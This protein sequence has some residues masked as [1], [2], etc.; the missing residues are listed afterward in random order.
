MKKTETTNVFTN[1][2]M[3]DINPLV[4]PNNV[5]SNALNATLITRNGNE[6]AL[7][8]DMGNCRVETA[9]LPEGY[10][11]LGTAQLGGIIYIVSYNPLIN[12]CQIGSFPSPERN[13][14]SDEYSDLNQRLSSD[15]FLTDVRYEISTEGQYIRDAKIQ[16][17]LSKKQI[18][19]STL[20]SGDKY[21][22]GATGL[23]NTDETFNNIVELNELNKYVKLSLATIDSNGRLV[24]LNTQN[25]Y[26]LTDDKKF[27]IYNGAI[28]SNTST[29]LDDYRSVINSPFQI[30]SSKIA[31]NLW[32]IAELRVIDTFNVTY[33]WTGYKEYELQSELQSEY[34]FK[35]QVTTTPEDIGIKYVQLHEFT[36]SNGNENN[37]FIDG[38][39]I[40][41]LKLFQERSEEDSIDN[42]SFELAISGNKDNIGGNTQ[43]IVTPCMPF[44]RYPQLDSTITINFDLIGSG[45]IQNTTWRY[46]KQD[47]SMY[48]LWDI[49]VYPRDN[50][51]VNS[52]ALM[53]YEFTS[54]ES[55]P[56]IEG[57]RGTSYDFQSDP[58]T[59][60]YK[61]N[62][63]SY[64]G[65]YSDYVQFSNNF[66][67]DTLYFVNIVIE[68]YNSDANKYEYRLY[69]KV[70][71]TNGVYNQ[72]YL[73]SNELDFDNVP[74]DLTCQ[75][76]FK[77]IQSAKLQYSSHTPD[78]ISENAIDEPL[79]G[80]DEYKCENAQEV[81]KGD[82]SF[83]DSYNTFS[84]DN[85]G[86][87]LLVNRGTASFNGTKQ[88]EVQSTNEQFNDEWVSDTSVPSKGD[89][90]YDYFNI[91]LS[92]DQEFS[93]NNREITFSL[94]GAI[95]NKVSANSKLSQATVNNYIAP[96]V[97][98]EQTL[99]KYNMSCRQEDGKVNCYWNTRYY[100]LGISAG[101]GDNNGTNSNYY[102][103]GQRTLTQ[104]DTEDKVTERLM[105]RCNAAEVLIGD[106]HVDNDNILSVIPDITNTVKCDSTIIPVILSNIGNNCAFVRN[107]A[108]L[109]DENS[110]NKE[111]IDYYPLA[112]ID[113]QK[114]THHTLY[115]DPSYNSNEPTLRINGK[116]ETDRVAAF[117]Q[118]YDSDLVTI[119][120]FIKGQD[121]LL[122]PTNNYFGITSADEKV[123]VYANYESIETGVDMS[124]SPLENGK[125]LSTF[126]AEF[127]CQVYVKHDISTIPAYIV[128]NIQYCTSTIETWNIKF[129][130]SIDN[131]INSED[132]LDYSKVLF[133]S[134]SMAYIKDHANSFDS[135]GFNQKKCFTINLD[136]VRNITYTHQH[137]TKLSSPSILSEYINAQGSATIDTYIKP[138]NGSASG[139]GSD[140]RIDISIDPS[141]TISQSKVYYHDWENHTLKEGLGVYE[142]D[143]KMSTS[144]EEIYVGRRNGRSV[145]SNSIDNPNAH[146]YWDYRGQKLYLSSSATSQNVYLM[147]FRPA[148][149]SYKTIRRTTEPDIKLFRNCNII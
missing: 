67:Q 81:I 137:V 55:Q 10:V 141:L 149:G 1:G 102:C 143:L 95:Y 106:A 138:I 80:Y 69:H 16:T 134:Y 101:G 97:Y 23:I 63:N 125:R 129:N 135:V 110:V 65:I 11:P 93:W 89:T 131:L 27:F 73:D 108:D 122:Y 72:I 99:Q 56:W 136:N 29:D 92:N 103:F 5:L 142:A 46:Y 12:K 41:N 39:P 8:N 120:L 77:T 98:D 104:L 113:D 58:N 112:N 62:R 91:D 44:G 144:S 127:L 87:D 124:I 2:L 59:I 17:S 114:R 18:S 52:I 57:T 107:A 36:N 83:K 70:L 148:E 26:N 119:Q 38:Q 84:L 51:T 13:L 42:L 3:M 15:D 43:F 75:T 9:Y 90:G 49:S 37:I 85:D 45:E 32:V 130:Y 117:K 115:I 123:Q 96:I 33:K 140:K 35:F 76:E 48:V 7:Q 146:L 54:I 61:N 64:S 21:I 100:S 145:I 128:N 53:A 88:V 47:E 34:T 118:S 111:Y 126:I 139:S 133:N 31:G 116:I 79:H 60:I 105:V 19:S 78:L 121:G 109:N 20:H 50:Q 22:V 94:T 66:K 24:Y 147:Y 68:Y 14:T 132:E 25:K 74:I 28:N 71:Y 82:V 40:S 4:T 86:I 30:F 6:Q